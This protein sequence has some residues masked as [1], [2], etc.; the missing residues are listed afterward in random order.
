MQA[1]E[2][3]G[4]ICGFLKYSWNWNSFCFFDSSKSHHGLWAIY[5][6]AKK[7]PEDCLNF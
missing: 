5:C 6:V 2:P 1:R 7:E 4:D 3:A